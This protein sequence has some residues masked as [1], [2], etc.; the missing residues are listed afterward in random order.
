MS[1][2]AYYEHSGRF[3]LK[4]LRLVLC[5]FGFHKWDDDRCVRCGKR[6]D[7]KTLAKL[8]RAIN[9]SHALVH[10][11]SKR[12]CF[13]DSF[14]PWDCGQLL[15]EARNHLPPGKWA[16]WVESELTFSVD[17]ADSYIR[18]YEKSF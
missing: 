16:S 17:E 4:P 7:W 15:L 14:A 12:T 6:V 18:F 3:S 5:L 11:P 1:A 2:P 8:A 9:V 10:D 13:D